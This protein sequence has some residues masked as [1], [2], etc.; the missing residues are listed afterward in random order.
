MLIRTQSAA[1]LESC[2]GGLQVPV[3]P[4][5]LGLDLGFRDYEESLRIQARIVSRRKTDSIPDCLLFVDYPPIITLGR[6]GKREHLLARPAELENRGVRFYAAGR[7]GDIT[8]HGPGQLVA[9]PI[10]DL[11][12]WRRDIGL[13]L[14]TLEFCLIET[15]LDFGLLSERLPGATGVWVGGRKIAAIGVRTSQW[16]TSHGLALNVNT[17]LEFFKLIV[18]CGLTGVEMTS[19]A[20]VLGHPLEMTEVRSCFSGHF[21]QAFGRSFQVADW[22]RGLQ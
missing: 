22:D 5:C 2:V 3:T 6:A 8:Y 12:G 17:D 18:P 21:A 7:G 16:V 19:M 14:R 11:K 10:L 1:Q 9:Y 20:T 15:L 4:S 13:Y